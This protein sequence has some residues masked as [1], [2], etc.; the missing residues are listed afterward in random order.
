MTKKIKAIMAIAVIAM[1]VWALSHNYYHKVVGQ[2]I[3]V[4]DNTVMVRQ[5]GVNNDCVYNVVVEDPEKYEEGG[6]CILR[7][8]KGE[9]DK[10]DRIVSIRPLD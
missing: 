5:K 3:T 10:Y 7:V 6:V 9:W 4:T 8:H 1:L 2:V